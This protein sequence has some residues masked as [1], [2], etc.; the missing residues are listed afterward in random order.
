M[1][2]RVHVE[3]DDVLDLLGE[4]GVVRALEGPHAVRLEMVGVPDPLNRSQRDPDRL[5]HG[6]SRP[7]GHLSRRFGTG[8]RQNLCD[9]TGRVWWRAG[10][11]RLVVKQAFHALFAE[12]PLPAP[13]RRTADARFAGNLQHRSALGREQHDARPQ[14]MLERTRTVFCNLDQPGSISLVQQHTNS[15]S[16][17]TDSHA[18]SDL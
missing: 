14:H 13:D 12:A 8:Q 17:G 16:H 3:A 9:G 4:G 15:L 11:T 5:G 18:S 7:V 6:A 1:G 2:R 10:R